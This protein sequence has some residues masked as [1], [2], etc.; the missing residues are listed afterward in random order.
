[1]SPEE[2]KIA[3]EPAFPGQY[4]EEP[5]DPDSPFGGRMVSPPDM[6]LLDWFAGQ[7]LAG[8]V[9]NPSEPWQPW[10][11]V[12]RMA[13]GAAEAMLAVRKEYKL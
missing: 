9:A 1:M 11:S 8:M 13:Y 6:S 3:I 7:A 4:Y 2:R 10:S 12:A 5:A